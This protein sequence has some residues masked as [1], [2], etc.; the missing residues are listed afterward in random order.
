MKN[1]LWKNF[2]KKLQNAVKGKGKESMNIWKRNAV[3]SV[4]VLFVCVALYLSWS[5]GR[6]PEDDVNVFDPAATPGPSSAAVLGTPGPSPASPGII[7]SGGSP[8]FDEARLSRK[9]ARDAA[10]DIYREAAGNESATQDIRDNAA[11]EIN[12][13]AQNTVAEANLE[14]M[15]KAKGFSECVVF[16][17]METAKVVVAE[18]E[19]GMTAGDANIIA[20][21]ILSECDIEPGNISIVHVKV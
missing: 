19:E 11:R 12:A 2:G 13:L 17:N 8:Y 14:N 5:Y 15:I 3:V 21:V 16:I 1:D 7:G 20:D 6:V 18:P 9:E 4:I 10:L